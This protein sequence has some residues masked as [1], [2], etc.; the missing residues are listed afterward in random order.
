MILPG[1]A[2]LPGDAW[3]WR[4]TL[5][6]EDASGVLLEDRERWTVRVGKADTFAAERE[7]VG[8]VV[9]GKVIAG[10]KEPP[11]TIK[12]R[13]A[14]DGTLTPGGDWSD[15]AVARALR[16]LL[17]PDVG[18]DRMLE[19][20]P[21]VLGTTLRRPDARLPGSDLKGALRIEVGLEKARL[22]GKEIHLIPS[23]KAPQG[24]SS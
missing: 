9:E 23:P 16:R 14:A 3:T 8:T 13:I 19:G 1:V 21:L 18:R 6:Y 11:E 2:F 17:R 24:G 10:A 20:W 12:G 4:A 5:R 22:G 7:F 15:P